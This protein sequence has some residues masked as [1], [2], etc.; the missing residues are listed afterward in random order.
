[1]SSPGKRHT[2]EFA[3]DIKRICV[4]STRPAL[5]MSVPVRY[6]AADLVIDTDIHMNEDIVQHHQMMIASTS[7]ATGSNTSITNNSNCDNTIIVNDCSEMMMM[8][9]QHPQQQQQKQHHIQDKN[10]I[11]IKKNNHSNPKM[12]MQS[13]KKYNKY[14][15]INGGS[16]N[17]E[18]RDQ[19]MMINDGG[20]RLGTPDAAAGSSSG[21]QKIMPSPP[22]SSHTTK[23]NP[24]DIFNNDNPNIIINNHHQKTQQQQQQEQVEGEHLIEQQHN[25]EKQQQLQQQQPKSPSPSTSF[26]N[27][28]FDNSND[29]QFV[30]S[31]DLITKLKEYDTLQDKYHTVLILPKESRR[32]VTAGGR[33]GSAYV[34]RCLKMWYELPSDVLFTAISLVDRF[35]DRM[36]VKPKHMACMS[37]ASFYLAIK[38][39]GLNQIPPEDL[40]TISQCGCTAGDLERM[41]G[42][43][44]NKLGV[45]MEQP[46]ITSLNFLRIY[47]NLFRN[48]AEELGF[49][50]FEFYKKFIKLEELEMRLE[51]L[52]CDVQTTIVSPATLALVLLCL[53]L[54]HHITESYPRKGSPEMKHLYEYI[55]FM[56]KFLRIPERVFMNGF[57]VVSDILKNYNGQN[58]QPYKQRLVWKLSSRTLRVL[59]PTNR[60][61][62]DLATIDEGIGNQQTIDEMDGCRSRTESLS[63]EEEEDWPTSPIIPIFE[64]C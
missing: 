53:H 31:E 12:L 4:S 63:S 8:D 17:A 51:V 22:S 43:I 21:I 27:N 64:Q 15:K 23:N 49:E 5:K 57:S 13:P 55:V 14:I 30:S 24:M 35:L 28:N 3:G 1:M 26:N 37:V 20:G 32:E 61:S 19:W 54:D 39:L 47:Y 16:S 34:L 9:Q 7:S 59:R 36:T 2:D 52:L 45:Q 62:S 6:S 33:D 11:I 44:A 18:M 48:M 56:Q 42:V 25:Q 40:V 58:K 38:Q 46:P 10:L 29:E 50:F 41:A 60:F